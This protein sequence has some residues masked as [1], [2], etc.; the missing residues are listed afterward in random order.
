MCSYPFPD[1]LA[2]TNRIIA[3]SKG[4]LENNANVD[5]FLMNPSD[6]KENNKYPSIGSFEGI[7]YIYPIGRIRFRNK[8]LHGLEIVSG[9]ILTLFSIAKKNRTY[10]YDALIISSDS[11]HVLFLYGMLAKILRTKAIFIFDEYPIPIRVYLKRKIPRFKILAY[12]VALRNMNGYISMTKNLADFYSK[13]RQKPSLILSSIT[14]VGRFDAVPQLPMKK[15]RICYMGN[16][17]LS[18]DNVDNIIRAFSIISKNNPDIDLFLY[19]KPSKNDETTL[20]KLV[21]ELDLNDK[22]HFDFATYAEVPSILKNAYILVSS[23]PDTLRAAGGFPTKLGEYLASGTPTLL[24]NVGEITDY[25]THGK[26]L[27]LA[28][29]NDPNDYAEKL[30]YIIKN[31]SHAKTISF[32]AREL[33][34]KNYSTKAAGKKILEFV[35]SLKTPI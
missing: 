26:D 33:V 21:G 32:S 1:G 18:K 4:L 9:V 12:S 23:Q 15:K 34:S 28:Q 17:Q 22:V 10:H 31:Y 20:L 24:T 7:N 6:F 30:D 19:G 5:I 14:D 3:Y 16:M 8:L 2:A 27:F 29:P 13:I 11:I 25:V 35:M